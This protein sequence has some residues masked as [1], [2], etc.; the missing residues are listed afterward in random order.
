MNT[1]ILEP[2]SRLHL[3]GTAK[4]SALHAHNNNIYAGLNNGDVQIWRVSTA[5][6]REAEAAGSA[7]P[8]RTES[9]SV[10]SFRSFSEVRRLFLD[11]DHSHVL[12]HERSFTNVPGTL[13]AL[14][15]VAALPIFADNSREVLLIGTAELLRV[16]EWVGPHL[17]LIRSFDEIRAYSHHAYVEIPALPSSDKGGN[18]QNPSANGV[19]P[20][21]P[22]QDSVSPRKLLLI[23]ARRRL[24]I[25]QVVHRS[26]NIV[27][28]VL[29]KE[30]SFKERVRGLCTL[31]H[32]STTTALI[33]TAQ[34]VFCLDLARGYELHD[35]SVDTSGVPSFT[36]ASSF[37]YFGLSTAGPQIF[38]VPFSST[39]AVFVRDTDVGFL[40]LETGNL[41][42]SESSIRLS[43]TPLSV[44]FLSPCYVMFVYA[45]TLEVVDLKTGVTIQ[46]FKH[47]LGNGANLFAAESSLV[48]LAAG[49]DLF[50][51]KMLPVQKQL[52]NFLSMG[53]TLVSAKSKRDPRNDLRLVGLQ[54]AIGLIVALDE[55]NE[56]FSD[57][58]DTYSTAPSAP[59]TSSP[60]M[61]QKQL[62]LRDLY[63]EK[64]TIY[65]E[66]Y[67][68]YHEA[69][70]ELASEW[71][72]SFHDI[73]SLF[74][75]FLNGSVQIKQSRT[76]QATSNK[77]MSKHTN[78]IKR[79]TVSE[80]ENINDNTPDDTRN[81]S[82]GTA[83]AVVSS[84]SD[85]KTDPTESI[86][87]LPQ[88]VKHFHKAVQNL[89]I[90]LTDQRRVHLSFLNSTDDDPFIPWKGVDLR[91]SDLYPGI[92]RKIL[93]TK[94]TEFASSIDTSLFLCYYFT[95][96][97]MLGPLLRL[98]HNRC[99][100]RVVNDT[101]LKRSSLDARQHTS[102]ISQLLDFY[103]G[104]S[105][106]DDALRLL[107]TLSSD[108]PSTINSTDST[109][110]STNNT[111]MYVKGPSLSI[112]YMQR[113]SNEYL[114]LIFKYSHWILTEDDKSAIPN[115]RL[116]FM[117]DSF[118]CEGY[119]R[120]RVLDFLSSV[121][122][123]DD[124]AITYL[125]WLLN[126]SGIL[127]APNRKRE[128]PKLSTRLCLLYLKKMASLDA[129][130]KSFYQSDPYQRMQKVLSSGVEY[131]PWTLLKNI[132]ASEDKYL[133]LTVFIYHRLGEH[134]KS[135]DILYNQLGD[136]DEAMQY[137]AR[138]Y[139]EP[140]G[141]KTGQKLLFKLLEDLLMHYDENQDSIARLL[142]LQ[143]NKIPT[144]Q[145]LTALPD[146]F[147]LHKLVVY[148]K[149][150]TQNLEECRFTT[151]MK[152][153]LYKIGSAK[154]HYDLV[155]AQSAHYGIT[156]PNQRCNV[157]QKPLGQS[158]T[159]ANAADEV[160]HYGC[161]NN[162][163]RPAMA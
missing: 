84:D 108:G 105:L 87:E 63:R 60:G 132:P 101:L 83:R 35:L 47:S 125:E 22:K 136:L 80:I 11:N 130:G 89:I 120:L 12:K 26:R 139:D 44:A 42:L 40:S 112:R 106:H 14:T 116:L 64:V 137:C 88:N 66:T 37:T 51:F 142:T 160:I 151:R 95:K 156:S 162:K 128:I 1:S 111:N 53:G 161:L 49:A 27:D 74:P 36:P 34:S 122:K 10:K 56:F 46:T 13:T 9:R 107:N 78:P 52:E 29:V 54:Q 153:Q 75:D 97:M 126:E 99:N 81:D 145:L 143:G 33:S 58:N 30:L 127:E 86:P 129:T 59:S 62:F 103:F 133:R 148:L 98:P 163:D 25:F 140:N 8:A 70:A 159:C 85:T 110:N 48:S 155:M 57:K 102:F 141:Q 154:A 104:R 146:S 45:K 3:P 7:G 28:F 65:F 121:I 158:V 91:V 131:E 92:D 135:V 79:V 15:T 114:D 68:K 19:S 21:P 72:V 109:N 152:S 41:V 20:A 6:E 23:S 16:Y 118:E 117:N 38:I 50:S 76:T 124:M 90:F 32:G 144:L 43:V 71:M 2:L 67:S 100:A 147:P 150:T 18:G 5:A 123:K 55:S 157:C 82:V 73:L 138:V 24:C 149:N 69:L 115:A 94:L 93:H 4:L 119:D 134:Q 39:D 61:K 31:D 77:S 17:N 96:P 113:L